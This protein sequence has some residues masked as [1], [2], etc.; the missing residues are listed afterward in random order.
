MH[1]IIHQM[2]PWPPGC[3]GPGT[4]DRLSSSGRWQPSAS[5][6]DPCHRG[7]VHHH[8]GGPAAGLLVHLRRVVHGR[9]RR[10]YHALHV[11]AVMMILLVAS[12]NVPW[13]RP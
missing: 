12:R 3:P 1:T 13:L 7:D 11:P 6:R 9:P 5:G 4:T 8:L 10:D 2:R